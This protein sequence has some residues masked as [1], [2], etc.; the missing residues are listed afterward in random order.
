MSVLGAFL[1]Y[2][3]H[4]LDRDIGAYIDRAEVAAE[5]EDMLEYLT[6]AQTALREKGYDR[7]QMGLIFPTAKTDLALYAR[8][9][10]NLVQRLHSIAKLNKAETAYQTALT[11]IRGT[12]KELGFPIGGIVWMKYWYVQIG[13][14]AAGI[15]T[16]L[17]FTIIPGIYRRRDMH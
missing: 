1:E 6:Q 15:F 2:Q 7:G 10:E 3:Q 13:F 9:L 4:I 12:I 16:F 5:R 17:S 14:Y 8:S 11:D